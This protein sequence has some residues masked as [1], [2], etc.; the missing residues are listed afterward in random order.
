MFMCC[1]E[2][3]QIQADKQGPYYQDLNLDKSYNQDAEDLNY[4]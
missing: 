3:E 2:S 1:S 4:K